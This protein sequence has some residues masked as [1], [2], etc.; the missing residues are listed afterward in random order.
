MLVPPA[1]KKLS[2]DSAAQNTAGVCL[3]WW[4]WAG[5]RGAG[6]CW[7]RVSGDAALGGW[8]RAAVAEGHPPHPCCGAGDQ[9][10]RCCGRRGAHHVGPSTGLP[11]CAPHVAADIPRASD[12]E[13]DGGHLE[14][15][16]ITLPDTIRQK[17]VTRS[18]HTQG[19]LG[20]SFWL[21][22][23]F[24]FGFFGPTLQHVEVPGP[25]IEPKPQQ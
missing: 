1:G 24:F 25:W 7:L 22:I 9:L 8:V 12:P 20:S 11:G 15:T 4:P 21:L 23:L 13:P 3:S 14:A 18:S 10:P 17:Q 16:A 19:R 2:P 5:S 6:W